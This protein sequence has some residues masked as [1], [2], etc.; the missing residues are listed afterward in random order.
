MVA[1]AL[2]AICLVACVFLVYV[3]VQFHRETSRT[4]S[5]RGKPPV[6]L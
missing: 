3:L 2:G 5:G 1:A 4:R 6:S